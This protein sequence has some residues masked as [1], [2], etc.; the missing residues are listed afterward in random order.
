MKTAFRL[1]KMKD[2]FQK[3]LCAG[4]QYKTPSPSQ[5]ITDVS[6]AEP[7]VYLGWQPIWSAMQAEA[8][9]PQYVL[10]NDPFSVCPAI[11]IMPG[12]MPINNVPE[13]RF[14]AYRKI[15]RPRQM[16]SSL[17][18]TI[19]FS[20]YNPGIRLPGFAA[21]LKSGQGLD[22]SLMLDAT[23]EGLLDLLNWMDDA[24][25]LMLRERIIPGTALVLDE[26][27]G[28]RSLFTD[29]NYIVDRR[30]IFYGFIVADYK[31]HAD[32]GS[33]QG[34]KRRVE[35]LLDDGKLTDNE[36]AYRQS[37]RGASVTGDVRHEVIP[38]GGQYVVTNEGG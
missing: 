30:P 5:D 9:T 17:A 19:L 29:Q 28:V 13:K 3:E 34:Y 8:N 27:T 25:E 14:D 26:E 4:R 12:T 32:T 20:I 16:G 35:R 31:G 18:V 38:G 1:L 23:E 22:K 11:T 6:T 37:I 10:N 15:M 24:A 7:R 2:W 21:S 36:E 33:D